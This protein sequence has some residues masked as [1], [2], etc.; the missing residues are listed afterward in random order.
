MLIFRNKRT[1]KIYAGGDWN[2]DPP[3]RRY[4]DGKY[5]LPMLFLEDEI[6][7]ARKRRNLPEKLFEAIPVELVDKEAVIRLDPK[8][9]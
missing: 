2:F 6:E 5:L 3:R 1:K 8:K 9:N 4:A 7:K